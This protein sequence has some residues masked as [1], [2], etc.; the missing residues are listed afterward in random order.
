MICQKIIENFRNKKKLIKF[1]KKASKDRRN[2]KIDFSKLNKLGFKKQIT[3]SEG[4]KEISNALN[5]NKKIKK[6]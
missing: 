1:S 3:L 4:I 6:K 2:Y 5:R